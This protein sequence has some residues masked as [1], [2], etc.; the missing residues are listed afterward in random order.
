MFIA[1]SIVTSV[2]VLLSTVGTLVTKFDFYGYAKVLEVFR[3]A[4]I[5]YLV[6]K[7]L[8]YISV[9]ML[10]IKRNQCSEIKL[11]CMCNICYCLG[12]RKFCCQET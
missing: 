6:H 3:S 10:R 12:D 7:L 11:L 2:A 4:D 1:V 9:L 5:Y 8:G